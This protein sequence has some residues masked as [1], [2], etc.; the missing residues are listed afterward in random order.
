MQTYSCTPKAQNRRALAFL[1]IFSLCLLISSLLLVFKLGILLLNQTL[2]LIFSAAL[3]WIIIKYFV[4]SYTYTVT[5]ME[6]APALIVTKNQGRRTTPVYHG[7]LSSLVDLYEYGKNG[8]ENPR[9]LCVENRYCFFVSIRPARRQI[10]YF[11]LKDGSC[12]SIGLEC[13]DAFL[14]I[15][16]EAL[17]YLRSRASEATLVGG[18]ESAEA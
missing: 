16:R 12:V 6:S 8:E 15:L 9:Q 11:L 4:T 2:F 14:K 13:D 1:C 3:V 18:E 17:A 10:L 7:E 5:L